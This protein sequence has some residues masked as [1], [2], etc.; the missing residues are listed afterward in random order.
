MQVE[1]YGLTMEAPGVSF[2]LWS[3]WRCAALEHK[4][5]DSLVSVPGGVEERTADEVRLDITETKSWKTCLQHLERVLKG[6]QEEGVDVGNEKRSW[7]WLLEGDVDADGFDHKGEKAAFW[8]F[9]R[10][11]IDRGG[12]AD[13]EKGEDVDLNGFGICVWGAEE[14]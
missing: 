6:W 9:L 7:R 1:L 10:L 2:Y 4:M 11:G 13:G 8:M 12:P 5:F 3:P 14:E